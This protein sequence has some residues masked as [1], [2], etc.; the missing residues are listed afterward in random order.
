M[1]P[2]IF[3][4]DDEAKNLTVFEITMPEEYEVHV[5][6]NPQSALDKMLDLEPWVVVSDQRMPGNMH[7]T[8]LLEHV[9]RVHPDAIRILATGYSDENLVVESVRTAQ[10]FDY[11]KKPWE[12]PELLASV[13]RAVDSYLQRKIAASLLKELETRNRVLE[14]L[15]Q[16]LEKH[17]R[18]EKRLRSE[19]ECW[20]PP[21][22]LD[23]LNS[24]EASFPIVRDL[25]G[26]TFDIVG[27]SKV[28]G[29]KVGEKYLRAHILHL[30]TEATLRH[31]G[32][33][34]SHSGDS[35]YSH[36]GLVS[37]TNNIFESAL[38]V[39]RDFRTGL[40]NIAQTYGIEVEC[41]LALHLARN[42]VLDM[43]EVGIK[44]LHGLRIQKSFDTTASDIDLLH[45][46]EKLTHSLPGSNVMMSK[47]FVEGLRNIPPR[48]LDL[49]I[50]QLPDRPGEIHLFML[51]SDKL[52]KEEVESFC[53]ANRIV[54]PK[55]AA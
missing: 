43:H 11:I 48:L 49:G 19:L 2:I 1:R 35:A 52:R 55:A 3:F 18:E 51:P 27:S 41:G 39:T 6:D 31:N 24:K 23:A 12:G 25:V 7:G 21:F 16:E 28:H 38:S 5:F 14:E 32:W 44:T 46:M 37:T 10:V 9:K 29:L 33:R 8:R 15:S 17:N 47:E 40:R 34:E 30:F 26:V 50:W 20:V 22:I 42:C 53:Q 45:R 13:Q 36:F 54:R 4:I